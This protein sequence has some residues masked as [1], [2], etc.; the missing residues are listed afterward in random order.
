MEGE[1]LFGLELEF[2]TTQFQSLIKK[3]AYKY[4]DTN[5]KRYVWVFSTKDIEDVVGILGKPVTFESQKDNINKLIELCPPLKEKIMM[6]R[7]KGKGEYSFVE[8]PDV[9]LVGEWQKNPTTG[10][11]EQAWISIPKENILINWEIIQGYPKNHWV[12]IRTQ[13]EHVCR[14]M[15]FDRMFRDS[16]TFDWSKFMGLH[17]KG[18]LP[19]VYYPVK[20]LAY[21]G[22]IAYSKRGQLKRIEE[23]LVFQ[24]QFIKNIKKGVKI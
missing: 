12:K 22:V 23:N 20:V 6:D 21:L 16:D 17:R 7:W 1:I 3:A 4:W 14:R 2:M 10:R 8:E 24:H 15:G 18:H 13:A 9:F 19:Y 5:K 11:P